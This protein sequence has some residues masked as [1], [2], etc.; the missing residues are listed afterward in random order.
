MP[1]PHLR[2][3]FVVGVAKNNAA[4]DKIRSVLRIVSKAG[5]SIPT[6][7]SLGLQMESLQLHVQGL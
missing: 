6:K 7:F 2:S 1:H 4:S 3:K 5:S